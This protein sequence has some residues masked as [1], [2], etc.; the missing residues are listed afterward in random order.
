MRC[1][2]CCKN[3]SNKNGICNCILPYYC[4]EWVEDEENTQI[5]ISYNDITL[6]D[7]IQ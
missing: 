6:I 7:K 1:P 3:C 2:K 5:N 4:N